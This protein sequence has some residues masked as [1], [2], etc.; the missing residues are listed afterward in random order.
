[1]KKT[2]CKVRLRSGDVLTYQ[3]REHGP[4]WLLNGRLLCGPQ[5]FFR[6]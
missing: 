5:Q 6:I 1:M 3:Q 4:V 2:L